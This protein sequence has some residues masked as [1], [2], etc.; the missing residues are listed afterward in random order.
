MIDISNNMLYNERIMKF[1][2]VTDTHLGLN[3]ASD[4]YHGV[5][6]DLFQRIISF[7]TIQGIN[8][9]VHLGDFSMTAKS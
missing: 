8:Q 9:V 6:L 3:K 1:V 7:C 4:F 2:L 5:T